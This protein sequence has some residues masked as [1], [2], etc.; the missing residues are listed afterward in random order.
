MN[1]NK[2]GNI[3]NNVI[4]NLT[5]RIEHLITDARTYIA[6]AVNISEV[7]TKYEIGRAI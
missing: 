6:S 7:I 4:S 3:N 2:S 5:N 1:N